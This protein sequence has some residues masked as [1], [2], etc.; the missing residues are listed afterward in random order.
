VKAVAV[1][2]LLVG[3]MAGP[4]S[5]VQLADREVYLMGTRARLAVYASSRERGL[6]TLERALAVLERTESELSTWRD[7]SDTSALNGQ[8][9]GTPWSA[10]PGLCR[11]FA[12]VWKWYRATGGAFDPGIG[13]LL[14]AWDVHGQGVVPNQPAAASARALSG[15]SLF[16]FDQRRC[17]VTR[18]QDASMDVGA[19]GKGEA[20]DRV[21]ATLSGEPWMIDLGG[22]VSVG[23]AAPPDEWR[24]AIA[25]PIHRDRAVLQ[26]S[27]TTG[28]LST[29]G[30]SERDLVVNGTRV[31]HIFDPRTGQ[32]SLFTGSVI[33]WHR[34]GL[35]ADALSTALFVMGPEDGR[36]WAEAN[37]I[38]ALYLIPD[39][40]DV[41]FEATSGF[42]RAPGLKVI[43]PE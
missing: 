1:M 41:R 9:V 39:G 42:G 18:L 16:S 43:E 35:A 31:S 30:G 8:P 36:R 32:P 15:L 26:L 28:S 25:H 19:F 3:V 24:I 37:G 7:S 17:T 33:V 14:A 22:Q 5:P 11:M 40:A 23:G 12:D 2:L 6:A 13:R 38:A 20:L 21:E 27:L 10:N 4:T 29:S 34:S